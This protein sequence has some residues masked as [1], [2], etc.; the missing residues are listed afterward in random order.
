MKPTEAKDWV[1]R[2]KGYPNWKATPTA[3]KVEHFD[4]VLELVTEGKYDH[5]IG[6]VAELREAQQSYFR[7][8]S[9]ADLARAKGL[10]S[11]VDRIIHTYKAEK[12]RQQPPPTPNLFGEY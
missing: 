3:W 9:H 4:K 11:A 1:A 5:L 7:T 12:P 2:M 6:K 8:R 10:E